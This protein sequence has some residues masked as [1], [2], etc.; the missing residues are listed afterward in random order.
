MWCWGADNLCQL[1]DG[2]TRLFRIAAASTA[3]RPR[4]KSTRSEPDTKHL[5][6]GGNTTCALRK[7]GTLWCWG[8]NI[9]GQLGVG[10]AP[11]YGGRHAVR[12]AGRGD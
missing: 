8:S 10:V 2:T 6:A 1:G 12:G 3:A 7:D 4:E 11:K 5:E 9:D